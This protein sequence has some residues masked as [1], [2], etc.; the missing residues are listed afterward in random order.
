MKRQD[1]FISRAWGHAGS[2]VSFRGAYS[3]FRSSILR[4]SVLHVNM[5]TIALLSILLVGV[6]SV[7]FTYGFAF[8][9]PSAGRTRTVVVS[10]CHDR[11]Y[12]TSRSHAHTIYASSEESQ[13][14]SDDD[15]T[16]NTNNSL[17][18]TEYKVASAV[19][20]ATAGL[21]LAQNGFLKPEVVYIASGP[22]LGGAIQYI[23]MGAA[24]NSRL[25]S[26]TYK[27]L[28]LFA[29]EY[30]VYS[31]FMV[32][33]F[34]IKAIVEKVKMPSTP[35]LLFGLSGLLASIPSIKGWF[36]GKDGEKSVFKEILG[37]TKDSVKGLVSLKNLNAAV[38][39]A[40]TL[41]VATSK[42]TKVVEIVY[43]FKVCE[44]MKG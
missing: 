3:I 37:G 9:V 14:S 40:G 31:V 12:P 2:A 7:S 27:R 21:I 42:V 44:R 11:G 16:S 41:F 36:K 29:T 5:R 33:T 4:P 20:F 35:Y 8:Q 39:L 19:Y 28:N 43:E 17:L 6:L 18:V 15:N 13:P 25:S 38:Y 10:N 30:A 23:L 22:F 32:L 26:D 1:I 34:L 24:F